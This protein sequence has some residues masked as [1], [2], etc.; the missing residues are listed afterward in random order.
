MKFSD[1]KFAQKL[2]L[3]FGLIILIAISLGLLAVINMRSVT[4]NAKHLAH[5]YVPEVEI[6]NAI[7][8][9]SLLTMYAMRGY[10]FTEE[11]QYYE[12]AKEIMLKLNESIKQ[13]E[14]LANESQQLDKLRQ[15][16]P[17]AKAAVEKYILL[18]TQT[19]ELNNHLRTIRDEM[20]TTAETF[21]YNCTSY[22]A[23][24]NELTLAEIRSG[25]RKANLEDRLKKIT[26]IGEVIEKGN[27][28]QIANFNAQATRNPEEFEKAFN[29]FN[30]DKEMADLYDLTNQAA[31]IKQLNLVTETAKQYKEEM[32]IF[33][34]NWKEREALNSERTKTGNEVIA[35][36]QEVAL[37]GIGHTAEIADEAALKLSASSALMVI[38]L[39]IALA[40]GIVLATVLTRSITTGLRRSVKFAEQVASGDLTADLEQQYLTRKDEIG[41]LSNALNH[42]VGKLREIAENIIA[43]AENIAGASQQMASTS[44]EM[45]QGASEQASSVEEVSSSMEEMASNIQQNTDNAQQTEKIAQKAA[46]GIREGNVATSTAVEAMKN[47]A[48]KIRI[49]NDIA[50]QTNILA[51]NAAVE[52]ARAGEHGKG[53]AVVAAEVRK[54]AERSKIAADEIDALSKNGVDVAERAGQKLNEIVPE[55]EKTAKLVQEIAAAS[56][57]QSTGSDQ[58]NNAMQQLNNVTQQNAAA[59]EEMATS[60][61]ELASQAEQLKEIIEYF[62]INRKSNSHLASTTRKFRNRVETVKPE[63][64]K[65]TAKGRIIEMDEVASDKDFESF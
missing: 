54:L 2:G 11:T 39:I 15:D 25:G 65:T 30:I 33:L 32:Q 47:I 55:I 12:T 7:E 43:G 24:Q 42:M 14:S 10:A 17:I 29:Q 46:V 41:T 44:Q 16:I 27:A 36:A 19:E 37:A 21:I 48:D 35:K 49:I 31:N 26:L 18:S 23:S 1:L 50:F 60:S 5:E 9:Y 62:K 34:K 53:F 56:I 3:G 6:S 8:R 52:A 57:E 4:V 28:L 40:I 13:A 58:V 38:G 59:S 63:T 20:H 64:K 61:E 51:L 45:S 22:L